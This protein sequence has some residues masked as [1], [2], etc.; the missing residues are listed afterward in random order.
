[1][2]GQRT[3][4]GAGRAACGFTLIEVLVAV[5]LMAVLAGLSWRGI[6]GLLRAQAHA[7][8]SA[9]QQ[10]LLQTAL[11]Q[12]QRDLDQ[13]VQVPALTTLDWDGKVLRLTRASTRVHEGEPPSLRVVA[14]AEQQ[15][16]GQSHW[17][18][19]QSQPISQRRQWLAAWNAAQLWAQG[20]GQSQYGQAVRLLPLVRWQIFYALEGRWSNP[21]SSQQLGWAGGPGPGGGG[22]Q[23]GLDQPFDRQERPPADGQRDGAPD[24]PGG[25]AP[26]NGQGNGEGEGEGNG[27]GGAEGEGNAQRYQSPAVRMRL[28]DGIRLE[29]ELAEHSGFGGRITRDWLSPLFGSAR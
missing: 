18:R 24:A 20:Q 25:Q 23:G 28:P 19:W 2:A 9:Q 16:D 13:L 1:M 10:A 14:W 3:S 17:L 12:W 15:I 4:P 21:L 8:R 5:A 11:A 22:P 27:E 29:L 6:D 7:E 26:G